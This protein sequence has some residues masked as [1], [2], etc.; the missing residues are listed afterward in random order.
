MLTHRLD[1]LASAMEALPRTRFSAVA[2]AVLAAVSPAQTTPK[3]MQRVFEAAQTVPSRTEKPLTLRQAMKAAN[4]PGVSIAVIHDWKL[5][6]AKGYGIADTKTR[7]AVDVRTLFQA[8]SISKPVMAMTVLGAVRERRFGLDDDVNSILKSWKLPASPHTAR[9]AVTP[10]TLLSHTSGLG[11]GF[12]FPGY[13]PGDPVPTLVQ[14]LKGEAPSN[15][16]AVRLARSP[17]TAYHYSGGGA[18][19]MQLALEDA[20]DQRLASLAKALVFDRIGMQ[21]SAYA[22][23]LDRKRDANAARGHDDNGKSMGAK[24]HV[25]P[26]H[27]AAGLWTTPTDLARFAIEVQ[28]ASTGK[29]DRV[30]TRSLA[31][32][33]LSPVGVGPF[34]IGFVVKRR[35]EG[36]YFEHGGSNWG[37]RCFLL[38]HKVKG[39][40]LVVMTNAESGSSL[41]SEVVQR[42]ERAYHWD[43][44]DKP[45]PR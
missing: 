45:V 36:W 2:C 13:A 10:R 9:R 33:M 26:E 23:P 19:M 15:V 18:T 30:L 24:W 4:V 28:L 6:W 37:F 22:Q 12:G 32:E 42:I 17:M 7:A 25:Y 1:N 5:H 40:G 16:G 39:Y 38:A 11:D 21:N 35:G 43:T 41:N 31:R 14:I 29:S 20:M 3:E 34:A 44:L 27:G 8:A